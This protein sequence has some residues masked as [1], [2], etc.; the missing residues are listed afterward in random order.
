MVLTIFDFQFSPLKYLRNKVLA[1]GNN[2]PS[3][4]DHILVSTL[5]F[6]SGMALT[7]IKAV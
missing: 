7:V 4:N 1:C 6:A 5:S 3:G 2:A